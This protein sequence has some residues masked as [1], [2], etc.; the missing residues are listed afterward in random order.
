MNQ[1]VSFE[2]LK[3]HF[4]NY[5]SFFRIIY[6]MLKNNKK[7]DTKI[8]AKMHTKRARQMNAFQNVV[9]WYFD[10][11]KIERRLGT[12]IQSSF[13]SI[14]T[15]S[16][17]QDTTFWKAFICLA[18]FLCILARIFASWF[19]LFFYITVSKF[20][21]NDSGFRIANENFDPCRQLESSEFFLVPCKTS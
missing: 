3:L 5:E 11:V 7:Q 4:R 8:R 10:E 6:V 18:C 19:L 15:P 1:L 9:T 12:C 14:F 2:S 20:G 21:N 17:Y 16:K 13:I